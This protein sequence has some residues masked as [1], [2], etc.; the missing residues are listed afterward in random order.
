MCIFR[1]KMYIFKLD[2][3]IFSLKIEILSACDEL[4]YIEFE[5]LCLFFLISR[6]TKLNEGV[7]E[8]ERRQT[9]NPSLFLQLPDKHDI[10]ALLV[11]QLQ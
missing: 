1:V 8:I 10:I 2:F 5:V 11:D 7:P 9:I 4:F 6:C 3:Y